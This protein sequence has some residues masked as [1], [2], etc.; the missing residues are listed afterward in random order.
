[1]KTISKESRPSLDKIKRIND[2]HHAILGFPIRVAHK[3][4]WVQLLENN[5]DEVLQANHLFQWYGHRGN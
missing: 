2:L 4:S 1:M 5:M 3:L